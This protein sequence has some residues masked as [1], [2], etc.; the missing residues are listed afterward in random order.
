MDHVG[1]VVVGAGV[2]GLAITRTLAQAGHEVL[3]IDAGEGLGTGTS[4][5]G[6]GVI[7][8]GLYY[9]PGSLKATLCVAGKAALYAFAEDH[10][11][12]HRRLGKLVVATSAEEEATLEKIAARAAANGVD[13]IEPLSG[14]AAAHLEP[15]LV[16]RAALWSPSTGVVDAQALL[17]ALRD[18]AET[19]GA[20]SAFSA[21]L[22]AVAREN[23][24]FALEIGGATPMRIG[25][26]QL[27][28]AAGHGAPAIGRLIE[29]LAAA[30]V[31][32]AYL[33]KGNYFAL[34]RPAPFER[35]IYP[36]PVP[37]G[38]GTHL[39]IDVAGTARFGPDVEWVD[40]LD[41]R[42]APE[43]ADGFYADIRRWWP[44]LPD[45]ALRPS[46]AGIRPK[47]AGPGQPGRDFV[48]EGPADHGIAG[49]VNLFGIESPGLTSSLAIADHVVGLLD[50]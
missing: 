2:V 38:V 10:G 19:F 14:A 46:H 40:M 18:D 33:A 20:V 31:P 11:V 50:A 43:R 22:L 6:S 3:V 26:A 36:V 15:A 24:G 39:T 41:Y 9:E 48:I 23:A 29:G 4:G 1:C 42:V 32:D 12:P 35:L 17:A 45:G 7:H 47:I 27:V 16:C 44:G 37:G 5:R 49:L 21:P 28:N 34:D 30:H 25:C 13:D 8:A